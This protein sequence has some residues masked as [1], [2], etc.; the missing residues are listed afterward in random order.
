MK[1]GTVPYFAYG[2]NLNPARMRARCPGAR[3]VGTATLRGWRLVE[4]LYA[5]IA[6][7]EGA[8]VRGVVYALTAR[9]VDALDRCEGWPRVYTD[10][11]VTVLMRRGGRMM[12]MTYLMTDGAVRERG[13]KPYPEW[14][15]AICSAGARANGIRD[16]FAE[17]KVG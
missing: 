10:A 6:P 16:D 3:I 15:R 14:Y 8:D 13:G 12:C 4:R 5:D 2:S 1:G 17:A 7:C 9:D 11:W